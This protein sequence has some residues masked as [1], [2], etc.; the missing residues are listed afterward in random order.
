[1]IPLALI[2][3]ASEHINRRRLSADASN[4]MRYAGVAMIYVASAA[5]MFIAGVGNSTWLPVVLAVLCVAGVLAG[6]RFRVRA[7]IHLGVGFLLL[8]LFSMIW[9]A[10]VDL[11]QTWVWYVSGIVLGV[12]VLALF[13]YLEK[14]RGQASEGGDDEPAR[15]APD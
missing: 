12:V 9:Y 3:L 10:A 8:D 7:F 15:E 5:D 1:M 14:R 13:A 4:A 11:E 2:V 6:I